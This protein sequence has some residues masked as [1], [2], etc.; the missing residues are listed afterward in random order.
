ME[1]LTFTKGDENRV[2]KS[3]GNAEIPHV[4]LFPI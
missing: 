3:G 4:L 1:Q 2:R